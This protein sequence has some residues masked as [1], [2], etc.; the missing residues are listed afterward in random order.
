MRHIL[1]LVCDMPPEL[2]YSDGSKQDRRKGPEMSDICAGQCR[3]QEREG[4]QEKKSLKTASA[5]HMHGLTD[6]LAHPDR[7]GGRNLS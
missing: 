7:A 4:R 2:T 6:R 3:I 1:P 5:S